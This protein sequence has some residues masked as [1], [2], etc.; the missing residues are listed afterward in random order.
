M[1]NQADLNSGYGDHRTLIPNSMHKHL[2]IMRK[3]RY[4]LTRK[5]RGNVLRCRSIHKSRIEVF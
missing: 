1:V 3:V 5:A 2:V 4:S